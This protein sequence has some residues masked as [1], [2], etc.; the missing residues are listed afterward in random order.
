MIVNGSGRLLGPDDIPS[1]RMADAE[2]RSLVQVN[3]YAIRDAASFLLK[4]YRGSASHPDRSVAL[5]CWA[6]RNFDDAED[7]FLC[8]QA[9]RT[10]AKMRELDAQSKG[11]LMFFRE[12]SLRLWREK[13]D[14]ILREP[15]YAEL[16][17]A[18]K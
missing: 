5:D 8:H 9:E 18:L 4:S 15:E 17:S 13:L 6:N 3:H 16:F 14:E 2:C 12:I 11:R 1:W 10:S 7:T